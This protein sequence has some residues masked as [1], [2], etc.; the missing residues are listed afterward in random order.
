MTFSVQPA[1]HTLQS[2][3]HSGA[4]GEAA[5]DSWQEPWLIAWGHALCF[6]LS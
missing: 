2:P 5:R 4:A 3:G 1:G 6:S